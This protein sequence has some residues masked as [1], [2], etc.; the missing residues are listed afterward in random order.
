M[1]LVRAPADDAPPS[2]EVALEVD[3]TRFE[4]LVVDR[5]AR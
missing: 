4:E 3:S 2:A 1:T 5:L